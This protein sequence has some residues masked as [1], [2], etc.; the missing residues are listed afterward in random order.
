MAAVLADVL[1]V[2]I[3]PGDKGVIA[4]AMDVGVAVLHIGHL[5]KLRGAVEAL[6]EVVELL[7][8]GGVVDEPPAQLGDK[9]R[10]AAPVGD[11]PG[12]QQLGVE[13]VQ[14]GNAV[15]TLM[16]KGIAE[17]IANELSKEGIDGKQS[18]T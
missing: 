3:A 8:L 15:P 1:I 11:D 6:G 10:I 4:K 7:L 5:Q 18:P 12:A 17:G 14:I 9:A 2:D 13:V 16:A